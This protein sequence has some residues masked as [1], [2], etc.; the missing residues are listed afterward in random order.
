METPR[1]VSFFVPRT[2]GNTRERAQ[3]I[4]DAET[5]TGTQN[6]L[7]RAYFR[8]LAKDP[9][10][11]P[12]STPSADPTAASSLQWIRHRNKSAM[13]PTRRTASQDPEP[14]KR[15]ILCNDKILMFSLDNSKICVLWCFWN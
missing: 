14:I 7:E 13:D 9:T 5:I 6:T 8:K 1:R 3:T 15:K 11:A 12:I 2:S 4:T 10:A